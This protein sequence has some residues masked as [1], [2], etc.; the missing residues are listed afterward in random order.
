MHGSFSC[1]TYTDTLLYKM[2]FIS[3]STII[4]QSKVHALKKVAVETTITQH[5]CTTFI[6]LHI[7]SWGDL[8]M[9]H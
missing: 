4:N 2:T 1:T 5:M 7:T 6:T 9:H 8:E 3:F